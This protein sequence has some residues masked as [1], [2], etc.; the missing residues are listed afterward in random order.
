MVVV[1]L[2]MGYLEVV[3]HDS[4][5]NWRQSRRARRL[6]HRY[7]GRYYLD[8]TMAHCAAM[9]F[10]RM[11]NNGLTHERASATF[12]TLNRAFD[13]GWQ[14]IGFMSLD[15]TKIP[16]ED[17][18]TLNSFP[19]LLVTLQVPHRSELMPNLPERSK[20]PRFRQKFEQWAD[21]THSD[22]DQID[23]RFLWGLVQTYLHT[24]FLAPLDPSA[25]LFCL[26]VLSPSRVKSIDRRCRTIFIRQKRSVPQPRACLSF[27]Q[28]SLT[29]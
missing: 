25:L 21:L 8:W 10:T 27:L 2:S 17:G 12:D 1:Y 15:A 22:Q 11:P 23:I 3:K 6:V 26:L 13:Q 20:H 18:P 16:R 5:G 9:R 7:N 29:A 24:F 4:A 14:L 19:A 28:I